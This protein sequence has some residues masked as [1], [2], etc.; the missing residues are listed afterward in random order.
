[1]L[2]AWKGLDLSNNVCD[3]EINWLTNE[4]VIRGK[5]NSK[6]NANSKTVLWLSPLIHKE[7]N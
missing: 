5:Q 4:K 2:V 6:S 1:M 3:Y 7:G